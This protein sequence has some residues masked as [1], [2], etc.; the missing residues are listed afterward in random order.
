MRTATFTEFR[1]KAKAFFDIVEQGS[2]VR[3]LRHG[4]AVADLIPVAGREGSLSW[5]RAGLRLSIKG[6]SL[7]R[8]I[9]KERKTSQ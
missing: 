1:R 6:I 3:I 7:S 2:T 5:K 4:R 9:L 8:E